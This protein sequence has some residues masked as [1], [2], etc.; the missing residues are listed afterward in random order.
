M[1]SK[2]WFELQEEI[3]VLQEM[4]Q[5]SKEK[6]LITEEFKEIQKEVNTSKHN[7]NITDT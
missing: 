1:D 2:T 4:N 6:A 7:E 3:T 5:W